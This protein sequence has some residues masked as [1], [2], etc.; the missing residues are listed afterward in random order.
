MYEKVQWV[1]VIEPN[2]LLIAE[3]LSNLEVKLRVKRREEIKTIQNKPAEHKFIS[4]R[5]H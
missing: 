1:L 4:S 2:I 3:P 5:P